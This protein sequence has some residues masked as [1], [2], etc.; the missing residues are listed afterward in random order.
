MVGPDILPGFPKNLQELPAYLLHSFL[1]LLFRDR[2]P[3]KR[4][5]IEPFFKF[6]Q[7]CIL[8]L[9]HLCNDPGHRVLHLCLGDHP[10]KDL[11]C[12]NFSVFQYPN[13]WVHLSFCSR[14]CPS[15]R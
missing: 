6:I 2:K 14:I 1:N 4:Y 7:G 8:A 5:F 10:G 9:S 12:R 3:V 11:L 15:P 13:H